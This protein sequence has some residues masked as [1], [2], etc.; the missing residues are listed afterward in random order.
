MARTAAPSL[1]HESQSLSSLITRTAGI[2][3]GIGP[4]FTHYGRKLNELAGRY[5]QGRYHLAV[6]GQF[7]RG[8]STLLNALTGDSILPMGVVPLTAAPT[9]LQYGKA[10]KITVRYQNGRST[11]EFT[12]ASTSER[13]TYLSGFVTEKGNPQN[14]RG[15]SEVQVDLPVPILSGGVVLID[16]PG[17]GSTYKHNTAATLNFLQECDAALFLISADPPITEMELEFLRH[18]KEKV[19]QLFFVLNKIDYLDEEELKEAL[20]FYQRVLAEEIGWTDEFPVFCVSARKGLRQKGTMIPVDGLPAAWRGWKPFSWSIWPGKSSMPWRKP[21][22]TVRWSLS[23][24]F[25]WRRA[26]PCKPSSCRSRNSRRKSA[27]SSKA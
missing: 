22:P 26:L 7:K 16:T 8:K 27:S 11:D 25:R 2:V 1:C 18:V 19:P 13:C 12:G 5:A 9:F 15:I 24:P 17:I 21:S 23:M 6:L 10:A 14:R 20:A 3:T 4:Q